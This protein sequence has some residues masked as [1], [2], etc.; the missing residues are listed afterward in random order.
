MI[1]LNSHQHFSDQMNKSSFLILFLLILIIPANAQ[2]KNVKAA[3]EAFAAHKYVTAIDHYRKA[4]TKIKKDEDEKTR[5]NFQ[6]AECYRL[7]N[8][9]NRAEIQYKRLAKIKYQEKEPI[10]LLHLAN[11]LLSNKKYKEALIQFEEYQLVAPDDPRG[12]N[13]ISSCAKAAE[14]EKIQYNY[15]VENLKKINSRE[16]DFSPAYANS[17]LNTIVFTS[18]RSIATGS[19]KDEWTNQDFSDLFITRV[20]AKGNFTI[21]VL[22]DNQDGNLESD[23][24]IN[25]GGNEGTP[26]LNNSFSTIYFTKCPANG[27]KNQGC[28][29]Y[30]S[31]RN[32]RNW[33]RP[34]PLQ[35]GNDSSSVVGHPTVS[36]DE[37]TI[38]FSS[39]NNSGYGGKDIW[40]SKRKNKDE[41]FG[42]PQNL[43][44]EINTPGD[45]MFP[46]LRNDTLLYFSSNGHIGMGGLDIYCATYKSGWGNVINLKTPFNSNADDFGIIFNPEK[47]EGF[48]SSNRKGARKDDLY[49]FY[50]PVLEYSIEGIVKNENSLQFIE[51]AEI[52]LLSSSGT[53]YVTHTNANGKY[54]FGTTQIKPNLTYEI[55]ASKADFFIQK[56]IITTEDLTNKKKIK[57]DFSLSPFPSEPILL[58][59]ILYDLGKWELKT[60][61]QDSLQDLIKTMDENKNLVIELASHTDSRDTDERND[62]LS[63]RRARSVVEYLIL[64]GI[65]PD[66]LVAK[67]Y[68]ERQPREL[69]ENMIKNGITFRKGSKL[70]EEFINGLKNNAEKE[71]A[72]ELNRRTEFRILNKDFE[73]KASKVELNLD[74]VNINLNPVTNEIMF[75]LDAQ[76]GV[77]TA[78]CLINDHKLDFS[79]Q[80]NYN[81]EIS[82][83]Q[84]LKLLNDGEIDKKDFKGDAESAL[85]NGT[86][87][88]QSVFKIKKLTIADKT[89]ENI[90]VI[91]N[92]RLKNSFQFGASV[93]LKFGNFTI[94]K[95]AKKIIFH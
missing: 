94:D 77:I 22:F 34:K 11:A 87:A 65:D 17:E 19:Q 84:A 16:D 3:D 72:H 64:R 58:P 7:T 63:Q 6:L 40:M 68:G 92:N 31:E 51:D 81:T 48:F 37:L 66:R 12:A 9:I 39:E 20:D 53:K 83:R 23:L 49:S 46:Y 74:K 1:V 8:N 15:V 28:K 95:A 59:E 33:G 93:L 18:G 14:W 25:T 75:T 80:E 60:Q 82:L 73:Q 70:T 69:K 43:G 21:P 78:N 62:I 90:E 86:I 10:I 26:Q 29:I 76:T 36:S 88:N 4:Y 42:K 45:E 61:Y 44:S 85:A 13:G 2:K 55:S 27:T 71:A 32:G 91:V 5:V 79:Y 30:T 57:Q 54:Q 24:T 38:Y 35:I 67:G 52:I 50:Q 47:E 89:I 56:Q 41:A